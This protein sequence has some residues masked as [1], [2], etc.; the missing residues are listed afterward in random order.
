[1]NLYYCTECMRIIEN[2]EKCTYCNSEV[3]KPLKKHSPVN[4]M[5]TKLKGRISRICKEKV[6]L[7]IRT[8]SYEKVL[9]EYNFEKLRKIL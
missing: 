1:M 9:K 5:G 3:V 8:E 4:V 7:V 2:E 6:T